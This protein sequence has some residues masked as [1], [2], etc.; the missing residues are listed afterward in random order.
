MHAQVIEDNY[1]A[2][3]QRGAQYLFQVNDKP[4]RVDRAIE[5]HHRFGALGSEGRDD[6][7]IRSVVQGHRPVHSLT[8]QSPAIAARTR[9]VDACFV[10]ELET[11]K[12]LRLY[13]FQ[14]RVVC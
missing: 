4:G 8:T 12:I 2:G 10:Y 9:Q 5:F 13:R 7:H 6:R 14:K 1:I 3:Y 11:R